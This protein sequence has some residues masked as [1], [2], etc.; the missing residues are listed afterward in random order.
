PLIY[1][2][3]TAVALQ[4]FFSGPLFPA[5]VTIVNIIIP[6]HLDV[7]AI[8]VASA[9]GG[10]GA[11]LIPFSIGILADVASVTVLQPVI[12]AVL[13]AMLVSICSC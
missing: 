13:G 12:Q 11:A 2:S 1:V 3:V 5:I 7:A 6:E 8:G 4:G 10:C 9:F